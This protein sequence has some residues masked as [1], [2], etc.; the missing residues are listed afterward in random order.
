MYNLFKKNPSNVSLWRSIDKLHEYQTLSLET[1]LNQFKPVGIGFNPSES[2]GPPTKTEKEGIQLRKK[3]HHL[4][5]ASP[6]WTSFWSYLD[7]IKPVGT[8]F[9]EAMEV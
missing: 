3:P 7:L 5:M 6:V 2:V 8:P 1:T 4:N 9:P